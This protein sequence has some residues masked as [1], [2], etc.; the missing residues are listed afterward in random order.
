MAGR[1]YKPTKRRNNWERLAATFEWLNMTSNSFA[2]HIGM[3]RSENLYHIK[4]GMFGITS[5]LANRI[6][7]HFPEIN[8]TWLLTGAGNMLTSQIRSG[9]N[10]PYYEEDIETLVPVIDEK[11]PSGFIDLPIFGGC[12]I[13]AQSQASEMTSNQN[14]TTQLFLR[15][16]EPTEVQQGCEY[17]FLL[18]KQVL[19]RKV[20]AVEGYDITLSTHNPEIVDDTTIDVTDII[21]AWLVVAKMDIL[22][23]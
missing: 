15:H 2:M 5:D 13:I 17:V 22:S 1:L 14:I 8:R 12:D 23:Y 19:W 4:R 9:N 11:E 6:T 16:V 18:H 3:T 21:H 7:Q 20:S 10:I